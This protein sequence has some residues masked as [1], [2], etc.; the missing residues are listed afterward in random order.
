MCFPPQVMH[1]LIVFGPTRSVIFHTAPLSREFVDNVI[2]IAQGDLQMTMADAEV[3][4]YAAK[5][6][7][8]QRKEEGRPRGLTLNNNS[9]SS[10][11]AHSGAGS[12]AIY[13]A[14]ALM[15]PKGY[16]SQSQPPKQYR[17][18]GQRFVSNKAVPEAAAT[19]TQQRQS[20]ALGTLATV[21]CMETN[22]KRVC[23]GNVVLFPSEHAWLK[24]HNASFVSVTKEDAPLTRQTRVA[25]PP[26]SADDGRTQGSSTPSSARS[27]SRLD[28]VPNPFANHDG[29]GPRPRKGS[30]SSGL[31]FV[32]T[33]S[34]MGNVAGGESGEATAS[35][36]SCALL[37]WRKI[38][39]RVV[40]LILHEDE[41][42]AVAQH[43][44]SNFI[45]L[46][47]EAFNTYH[48]RSS[49]GG[50]AASVS[51]GVVETATQQALTRVEEMVKADTAFEQ[52]PT[53]RDML[54][55]PELIQEVYSTVAPG[56]VPALIDTPV[57]KAAF[58]RHMSALP[59]FSVKK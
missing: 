26:Q 23:Q 15:G 55:R 6:R 42:L 46:L 57:A 51:E 59:G 8:Q 28:D 27:S 58:H 41:S 11:V 22:F 53:L 25:Q 54:L 21:K 44:M 48:I 14:S 40:V 12:E 24:H 20:T 37:F 47:V 49:V 5:R 13:R 43:V 17:P 52:L 4:A 56:H 50:A 39:D 38:A 10:V 30:G 3:N 31:G 35:T 19:V 29:K 9:F 18:A 7:R 33:G 2:S 36:D 1:G 45:V 16:A 34:Y 32:A